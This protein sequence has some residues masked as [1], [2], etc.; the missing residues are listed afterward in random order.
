MSRYYF[1]LGNTPELTLAELEQ[2]LPAKPA[3]FETELAQA[4]LNPNFS[5]EKLQQQ[6]GGVVKILEHLTNLETK[7]PEEIKEAVVSNLL[8][9]HQSEQKITFSLFYPQADFQP[10][11]SLTQIKKALNKHVS[12]VRYLE[13]DPAGLSAAVL[14]HQDVLELAIFTVEEQLVLAKTVTIQDIDDW[15][16]R[17]RQKPYADHQRGMLP[18][19]VARM[20]VNI[21]KGNLTATKQNNQPTLYDPFCGSGT[22]LMEAILRG[23]EVQGADLS[24]EAVVGTQK[25]LEWLSQEYQLESKFSVEQRDATHGFAHQLQPWVDTIVTEPFL[26]KQTPKQAELPNIFKGLYRTYLGTMKNWRQILRHGAVVVVITPIVEGKNKTY[27]LQKLIDNW[28]DLGYTT[29][30]QPIEY[31]RSKARVKRQINFLRYHKA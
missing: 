6:A 19:K 10:K 17:D 20:M 4:E 23:F 18:P 25:N 31:S 13:S 26:G 1:Q 22:V 3:Q 8:A 9:E 12:N 16:K 21:A 29:I 30:S 14:L 7:E 5:P 27:R 11:L 28:S 2:L 24:A 15:T